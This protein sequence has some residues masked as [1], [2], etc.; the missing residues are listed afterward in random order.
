MVD[1]RFTSWP[2]VMRKIKSTL[3]PTHKNPRNLFLKS[4]LFY[5]LPWMEKRRDGFEGYLYPYHLPIRQGESDAAFRNLSQKYKKS[6]FP[7]TLKQYH[8]ARICSCTLNLNDIATTSCQ[9][10]C[11]LIYLGRMNEFWDDHIKHLPICWTK[12]LMMEIDSYVWM[13]LNIVLILSKMIML[14]VHCFNPNI[15]IIHR[16]SGSKDKPHW[17]NT[18]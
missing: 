18:F 3:R 8:I 14:Q 11:V 7:Q 1:I 5:T 10:S 17:V 16:V 13:W 6:I 12:Q 2:K 4:V 9:T 15:V